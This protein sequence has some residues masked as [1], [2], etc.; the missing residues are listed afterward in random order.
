VFQYTPT[1]TRTY[2]NHGV[3]D[4]QALADTLRAL[5]E[6]YRY[7]LNRNKLATNTGFAIL[8]T[9]AELDET[10]LIF[11]RRFWREMN[12]GSFSWGV[13]PFV[14]EIKSLL[15]LIQRV[16]QLMS[17]ADY[18]DQEDTQ[19]APFRTTHFG[20]VEFDISQIEFRHRLT[21]EATYGDLGAAVWLDALGYYPDLATAWDLVPLSFVVNWL[22]PVGSFLESYRTG[23]ITHLPFSGWST[24]NF[25]CSWVRHTRNS[26][27]ESVYPYGGSYELFVRDFNTTILELGE[28][29]HSL[30]FEMPSI[31]Q[32]FNTL[33][34]ALESAKYR[35]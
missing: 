4:G 30:Q 20:R 24:L 19:I 28:Q 6:P 10:L 16:E 31:T 17:Q 25:K 12:Y 13:L 9:L 2:I 23:W 21:G 22:L 35:F 1:S 14:G 15:T 18:E 34:L 7:A 29:S 3:L 26:A 8:Q 11:T 32:L 33:W 27:G 5:A